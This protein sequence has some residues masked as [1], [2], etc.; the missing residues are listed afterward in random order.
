MEIYCLSCKKVT[1]SKNIKAKITKNN[2]PYLI[3][4]CINCNKLKSILFILCYIENKDDFIN[5][6][7]LFDSNNFLE[8]ELI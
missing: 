7:T 3:A 4:K 8:N 2:R 1:R 5:F 6:L